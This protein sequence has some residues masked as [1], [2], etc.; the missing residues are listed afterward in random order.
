M[1]KLAMTLL[2]A[3]AIQAAAQAPSTNPVSIQVN[4]AKPVGAYTP[5]YR[6]FGY[7][8]SNYT[9]MKYGKQLLGEL[10]DLSPE[11][12]YIRAHHLLTSGNGVAELKWSS[13]NVFTVDANGKPVYDFT[14]TDKTFDE[15]QRAG[16]R[17]VVELGFMPKDLATKIPGVDEYQVR[18][19]KS[20]ISGA[21]N[22]PPRDY[23]LWGELVRRYTEHLVQRYGKSE[24]SSWYFEVWNEPD[25]AY[26]HG[27]PEEYY[28]LYDYAVDGVRKALPNAIV[29]GPASTGPASEK[30]SV[31]LNNFLKHCLNDKSAADGKAIPLD[32]ISFHPKGRPTVVDGHVQ[33]GLA[34]E[35]NAAAK[36]FSIVASYPKYA[37]LPIILSEADPEGCAAC[38]MK[39]NP[40][41]A[42]RNG[43]LYPAYTAT[44]IKSLFDLRDQY[45]VD[46]IAM[47]SWAF[48]FEGKEY[49]EGF[50]TLSTNGIDK[51]ILNVFRMAG[52]MSGER[53][54]TNST[55]QIPLKDILSSGVRN[56]D[57]VDALA[58]KG[59][60]EAAVMIWDY[61][62]D[63]VP[64]VGAQVQVT[65]SGIPSNIKRVLLQHYRIDETHSN[66]YHVWKAM[67]SPQEPTQ[68]QYA[69]LKEAGQ[70][71]LL[72]SPKWLNVADGKVTI[73]TELPRQ[74][75][76]LLHLKW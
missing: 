22:N 65:I 64:A 56:A 7:D 63:D 37:H 3:A 21:S 76:S 55:G 47:L 13:S 43:P 50:R 31:F 19:P 70:L 58:T 4:L 73:A 53:V 68:A 1:H 25:I 57:D 34:N 61:H 2:C 39:V 72:S 28:K 66:S 8:E 32:F 40:A 51:P 6:W 9:T 54:S 24:V 15:F 42:Y 67:G 33:M 69:R 62:D 29:G 26:W 23:A 38:S 12:V 52:L 18:Y 5:I 41:N 45:K 60:R 11:P 27:T 35:L 16:V 20:T 46:L 44:A 36:G 71:E 10:H 59:D 14:I 30:A 75:T 49:F 17:P 48:E 74:A